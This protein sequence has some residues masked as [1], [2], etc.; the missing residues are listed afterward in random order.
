MADEERAMRERAV[1]WIERTCAEQGI[2]V[3]MTDPLA[4]AEIAEIL[5]SGRDNRTSRGRW[6]AWASV[7]E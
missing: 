3:K 5:R 6:R 1:A 7:P 2:P 4:L